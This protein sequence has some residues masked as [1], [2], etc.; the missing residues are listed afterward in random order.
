M[1]IEE[2]RTDCAKAC[3][4][5]MDVCLIGDGSSFTCRAEYARCQIHCTAT[6][7]EE[8]DAQFQ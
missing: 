4:K 3:T 7:R 5:Q 6:A 2:I 1:D 8:G